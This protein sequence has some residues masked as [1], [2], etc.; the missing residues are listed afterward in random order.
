[1]GERSKRIQKTISIAIVA[2]IAVILGGEIVVDRLHA[3]N[4]DH[5]RQTAENEL[6]LARESLDL[7]LLQKAIQL[8]V[9]QVQQFLTDVSATRGLDG[10]ADGFDLARE[11]ADSFV[12]NLAAARDLARRL[13]AD[14]TLSTLDELEAAFPP[15]Y[16]LGQR[17]ARAYVAEGPAGGNRLMGDFDATAQRLGEAVDKAKTSIDGLLERIDRHQAAADADASDR[18]A[19]A[20]AL[21]YVLSFLTI[22]TGI[23]LIL[24]TRRKLLAPLDRVTEALDRLARSERVGDLAEAGRRDEIGDLGRAFQAF[25]RAAEEKAKLE[26]DAAVRRQEADEERDRAAEFQAVT[27]REQAMVVAAIGK[28][29]SAVSD[30]RLAYRIEAQFPAAYEGLKA[31]FNAAVATLDRTM[32]TISDGGEQIRVGSQ[33]MFQATDDLSRRTEQ[34]AASLEETAAALGEVTEGIRRTAENVGHARSAVTLAKQEAEQSAS[35]VDGAIAAMG[36]IENSSQ[37]ISQIIGVIDEIAFQ[38]NLLALNAGVEAARAGE[39]GK[40][41]AVVAQEVRALAQRSAEAAR[42]IKALIGRSASQVEDGVQLVG[43]A[44]KALRSIAEHVGTINGI[45]QEIARSSEEQAS[46]LAEVNTAV[47]NMDQMTQQNA[48]MVE[49]STAAANHLLKETDELARLIGQ[50]ELAN[51]SATVRAQPTR[52]QAKAPAAPSGGARRVVGN[53]ALVRSAE[54]AEEGG[55]SEF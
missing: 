22:A 45:V 27:A 42:E 30:G 3:T 34:Q 40:G 44:G 4:T 49:Q 8:D 32:A 1:M 33:E 18:A 38:T 25:K 12:V 36:S 19:I 53:L 48:A 5:L 29:L 37:Q 21:S 47:A 20:A 10:L 52:V 23:A 39:A 41:F 11:H 26:Q 6:A 50:F 16:D 51:A 54:A 17:M 35:V 31:D 9:V 46:S 14:E 28:A 24:F 7:A 2:A 55:W 43:A 13:G 15:F